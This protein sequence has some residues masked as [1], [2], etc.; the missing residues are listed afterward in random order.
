MLQSFQESGVKR[1]L[2]N[3]FSLRQGKKEKLEEEDPAELQFLGT[4]RQQDLLATCI[5]PI[6]GW[7]EW[8][9][10]WFSIRGRLLLE[11]KPSGRWMS[12]EPLKKKPA[13][14]APSFPR[15]VYMFNT[16]LC[17]FFLLEFLI[18]VTY[19]TIYLPAVEAWIQFVPSVCDIGNLPCIWSTPRNVNKK[20]TNTTW[21]SQWEGWDIFSECYNG[22]ENKLIWNFLLGRRSCWS[23]RDCRKHYLGDKWWFRTTSM[24][25]G[26]TELALSKAMC[27]QTCRPVEEGSTRIAFLQMY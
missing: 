16:L 6:T 27:A 10:P 7:L 22:G 4:G 3:G 17:L 19:S 18:M 23:P 24:G 1:T 11:G 15:C 21:T 9:K 14:L 8:R 13:L 26:T 5:H 25:M 20:N 12:T 2:S